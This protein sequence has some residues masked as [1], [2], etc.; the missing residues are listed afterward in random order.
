MD[1]I[2]FNELVWFGF[3]LLD[4]SAVVLLFRY[5]GRVGLIALMVFSLVL[6]NIQVLKVVELF[7]ITTTLGGVLSAFGCAPAG[8][9]AGATRRLPG[10]G[11]TVAATFS[12]NA[13]S[14]GVNPRG[15]LISRRYGSTLLW[16]RES[17]P[18]RVRSSRLRS[19]G[20]CR[21]PPRR[22]RTGSR[23]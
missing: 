22:Y 1:F 13:A 11:S 12:H 9:T 6:C 2:G 19:A 5:F 15:A 3:A 21:P 23:P 18:A 10:N 17:R 8:P 16:A 4:L 14:S 7:G 20:R